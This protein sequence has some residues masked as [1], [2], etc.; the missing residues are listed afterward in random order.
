MTRFIHEPTSGYFVWTKKGKAPQFHHPDLKSATCEAERLSAL[1][2][3]QK[4]HV[5]A[6]CLKISVQEVPP[7]SARNSAAG[8]AP[9]APAAQS[10]EGRA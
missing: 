3:G 8:E 10:E 4:F 9:V 1:H 6:S 2:P 5:M 7:A